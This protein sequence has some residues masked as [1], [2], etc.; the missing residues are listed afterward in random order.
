MGEDHR[1]LF[2]WEVSLRHNHQPVSSKYLG[3]CNIFFEKKCIA[4]YLISSWSSVKKMVLKASIKKFPEIMF[5]WTTVL[6]KYN[7]QMLKNTI[8]ESVEIL[9]CHSV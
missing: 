3:L 6:Y 9:L 5:F 1:T 4:W 7:C 2:R 8:I